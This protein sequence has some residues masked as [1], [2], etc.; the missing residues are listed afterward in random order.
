M[1]V[2]D[3]VFAKSPQHDNANTNKITPISSPVSSTTSSTSNNTNILFN[4]SNTGNNSTQHTN[5]LFT[6]DTHDLYYIAEHMCGLRGC[7]PIQLSDK[8]YRFR[9]YKQIFTD[10]ECITWLLYHGY[11]TSISDGISLCHRLMKQNIFQ[12]VTGNTNNELFTYNNSYYRFDT[13]YRS[14]VLQY[15]S[16][17]T[18]RLKLDKIDCRHIIDEL[19]TDAIRMRSDSNGNKQKLSNRRTSLNHNNQNNT[20]QSIIPTSS[21]FNK[22]TLNK[23]HTFPG[24][25]NNTTI[26]ESDSA[27]LHTIDNELEIQLKQRRNDGGFTG[28]EL[29]NY[30]LQHNIVHNIRDAITLGQWMLTNHII[31]F[32]AYDECIANQLIAQQQYILQCKDNQL[33]KNINKSNIDKYKT[34][35]NSVNNNWSADINNSNNNQSMQ[36]R[37]APD[38][39]NLQYNN[40]SI[41]HTSINNNSSNSSAWLGVVR[42]GITV[43]IGFKN[44]H[45]WYQ[46][47][48]IARQ[49]SQTN[50]YGTPVVQHDNE[51]ITGKHMKKS[52]I[53]Y[54]SA[55]TRLTKQYQPIQYD[56]SYA[57]SWEFV[58][59]FGDDSTSYD[60]NDADDLVT[61]VEFSHTGKYLAIGD[62]AGRVSI[63][64]ETNIHTNKQHTTQPLEYEF[65]S[66]FQS[67]TPQFDS[68]KSV[69]VECKINCIEW[70]N[71]I[72]HNNLSLFTCNDKTIKLWKIQQ[73]FNPVARQQH[74]LNLLQQKQLQHN[75]NPTSDDII[76]LTDNELDDLPI[77]A[78][79]KGIYDNSHNYNIHSLSTSSDGE[80]FLSADDLRI[81][82]WNVDHTDTAYNIID[83]KPN[84]MAQIDELITVAQF[85]PYHAH[86]LLHG[87]SK[88]ITNI[89]DLRTYSIIDKQTCHVLQFKSIHSSQHKKTYFTEI[90][91][92]ILDAT[93]S[94]CGSYILTRDYMQC[95]L[96]DIRM[97]TQPLYI[98]V[99]HPQLQSQCTQ[100]LDNEAIFDQFQCDISP[101]SLNYVT[102]TYSHCFTLHSVINNTTTTIQAK[103]DAR[104]PSVVNEWINTNNNQSS[105][106]HSTNPHSTNSN[107]H[108]T[109]TGNVNIH[110][111]ASDQAQNMILHNSS[112]NTFNI[113][114]VAVG[115]NTGGI[116]IINNTNGTINININNNN[117]STNSSTN[118]YNSDTRF[119]HKLLYNNSMNSKDAHDKT[120]NNVKYV[121]VNDTNN[122]NTATVSHSLLQNTIAPTHHTRHISVFNSIQ[123]DYN[124]KVLKVSWHPCIN[125]V[126]VAGLY[127]LYLYQTKLTE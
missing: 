95:S 69:E 100:L 101:N 57:A 49:R 66:E 108:N 75:N 52:S 6:T 61:A 115:Q 8:K 3:K 25:P 2:F 83:M 123:S 18:Q 71:T 124:K 85:H 46:M 84:D 125:A 21:L 103:D 106:S 62:K 24:T 99:V 98:S 94:H 86:Q 82:L 104:A 43:P 73:K 48:S 63:V 116:N 45:V 110:G 109:N 111:S 120:N 17:D 91:D 7:S 39:I 88:G 70:L 96:W 113:N 30:L 122:N 68:L 16:S 76:D 60:Y 56:P 77:T 27:V 23:P 92:S 117:L 42:S 90:T 10:I 127:K 105:S 102:G 58:Q 64:Q 81:N 126:A 41:Q 51:L 47:P 59:S 93:Y 36:L 26:L 20:M 12:R 97:S 74:Q 38:I 72:Q 4:P 78:S 54:D 121:Y 1:G 114:S 11:C 14:I 31:N 29:C 22:S 5:R 79:C 44:D 9:Q 28:N 87:S 15:T 107:S 35:T 19:I 37:S 118:T 34:Q 55:Y 89:V 65:C 53:T 40:Y 32:V 33:N 119:N 112:N 80:S 13:S 50:L 67:H